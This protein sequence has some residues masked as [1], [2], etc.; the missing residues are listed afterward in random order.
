MPDNGSDLGAELHD[1]ARR[2]IKEV[3]GASVEMK[4][5]AFKA[6]STFYLQ[7]T[8]RGN[9]LDD[10]EED[11]GPSISDMRRRVAEAGSEGK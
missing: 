8:K 7:A 4:V 9:R 3:E 5:A 6:L 2:L 1:M 10:S 11:A